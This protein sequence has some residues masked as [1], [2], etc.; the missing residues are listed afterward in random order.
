MKIRQIKYRGLILFVCTWVICGYALPFRPAVAHARTGSATLGAILADGSGQVIYKKN[1]DRPFIPASILKILTGL[2]A[3]DVLGA[4][5]RFPTLFYFDDTTKNF[6]VK[7]FGDPLFISEVIQQFCRQTLQTYQIKRINRIIVDDSYFSK[8]IT[9]P[10]KGASLNPYDATVGALSANFNTIMFTRS[11]GHTFISAEPQTP[12]LPV[13]L[14]EIRQTGLTQG[15]IVL[16]PEKSRIYAG[17]LIEYFLTTKGI[18]ILN[19]V[20]LGD[21]PEKTD[22]VSH[23]FYSP[24]GLTEVVQK[25]LKYSNNFMANQLVLAMGAKEH[26]APATLEKGVASVKRFAEQKLNLTGPI[27]TEGSGLSR[28]NRITPEQMLAV[29][30]AFKPYYELLNKQGTDHYKT[31]TLTGIRTRAGY[32]SGKDHRLYPY[33]IMTQNDHNAYHRA[34]KKLKQLVDTHS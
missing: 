9:I 33:V 8:K 7:G 26:Q 17:L 29:L 25:L 4:S 19:P 24:F 20:R 18:D 31:G 11:S 34:Y 21:F 32:F 6:Y 5:Y 12:L 2:A 16:S 28:E 3:F 22:W 10:G 13:F 15:R 30:F 27:L 14:K 1:A 23:T